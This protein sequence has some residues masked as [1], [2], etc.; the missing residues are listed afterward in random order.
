M[1]VC[2]CVC[3]CV[4]NNGQH[5]KKQYIYDFNPIHDFIYDI[6]T[7]FLTMVNIPTNKLPSSNEQDNIAWD[8]TDINIK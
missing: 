6:Y 4:F 2:V 1:C 8:I 3:V 7:S 5:S